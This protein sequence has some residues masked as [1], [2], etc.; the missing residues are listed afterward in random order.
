[1]PFFELNFELNFINEKKNIRKNSFWPETF[2]RYVYISQQQ[3]IV[4]P[5]YSKCQTKTWYHNANMLKNT[6]IACSFLLVRVIK[7]LLWH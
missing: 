7:T 4:L 6:I 3:Q 5:Y 1:M 2:E